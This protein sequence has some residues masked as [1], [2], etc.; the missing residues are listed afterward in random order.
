MSAR[1]PDKKADRQ[2][3]QLP[4]QQERALLPLSRQI[5]APMELQIQVT[6]L[7]SANDEKVEIARSQPESEEG[8]VLDANS[9]ACRLHAMDREDL[10]GSQVLDLA[11]EEDINLKADLAAMWSLLVRASDDPGDPFRTPALATIGNAGPSVRTVVLRDV[12]AGLGR[13]V[14]Y[15]DRRSPKIADLRQNPRAEWLFYNPAKKN[16]IRASGLSTIH[17]G[18]DI[19]REAWRGVPLPNRA[20]Y[21]TSKPPG[22]TLAPGES[23]FPSAWKGA[24]PTL[25]QSGAGFTNFTVIETEITS[26][27][28]LSLRPG[29]NEREQFERGKSGFWTR[30]TIVP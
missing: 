2:P 12:I 5:I 13:L 17:I 20:N 1:I 24:L 3:R 4:P 11:P 16:Q 14:C 10:I 18:D 26:I 27:D 23:P 15:S 29:E 21:C 9:A 22:A 30:R 7:R 19:A 25:E 6:K 8:I 28:W